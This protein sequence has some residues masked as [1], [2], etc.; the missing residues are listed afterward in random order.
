MTLNNHIMKL[1]NLIAAALSLMG[2]ALYAQVTIGENTYATDTLMRRQVGPGMITTIVRIPDYPLNVYI[3][4]TDLNNPYNRVETTLGYN[5]LGRTETLVNAANRNRTATKRPIVG[6]NGNFWCVSAEYPPREFELGTPYCSVVRNDSIYVNAETNAD[7]WSYGPTHTGGTAIAQDKTLY[8]GIIIP[9]ATITS[10]KLPNPVTFSTVNRRC[11]MD[12]ITLWTPA[13]SRTREFEDNWVTYTEK[14]DAHA[15]NYYLRLKE[16]SRWAINQDMTFVV[17][18]IVTDA[19]RQTLGD[20]DACFTAT[21]TQK[22]LLAPL[23]VGDEITVNYAM[24]YGSDED[25]RQQPKI[26]NMIEGLAVV[27]KNGELTYRNYDDSYNTRTY[28]RTAYGASADGKKL[29]MMVIDMSTSKKYGYSKGCSTEVMC[30][31]MKSLCPDVNNIVAMDAGGSAMM[32][33][34]GEIINTTT[35]GTPRAIA[36]GWLVEAVGEEDNEVASIAFDDY[37]TQIPI[38]STYR[39]KMLGYNQ[40]GELVDTDVQGFSLSCDEALG[41]A[42]GNTFT[43]GGTP[44]QGTLTATL[45]GMTATIPVT[46]LPAQP[47]IK[48]KPVIVI[49][50]REYPVEV[51]ATVDNTTYTYDHTKL[52]WDIDHP[53]IASIEG[54]VLKGIK[55]GIANITC[56]IGDFTDQDEVHVEISDKPYIH[57]SLDGWEYGG[58]GAKN[59]V[60]DPETGIATFTMGTS[61]TPYLNMEKDVT[62]FGLPDSIG[63][64]FSCTLQVPSVQ[65]DVRNA[66][67]TSMNYQTLDVA[68]SEDTDAPHTVCIDLGQLGGADHVTTYP[69]S[70]KDIQF[71]LKKGTNKDNT[72]TI[73]RI[74]A[75]YPVQQAQPVL[76]DVNGDGE[77]G[78]ADVTLLVSLLMSQESNERSDVN[79]DGETG[80]ADVTALVQILLQ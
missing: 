33:V 14:G 75:H 27:M 56:Q 80:V 43:A 25:V 60:M 18:N 58:S 23:N 76:G 19:D 5:T 16:G 41:V 38:Y 8:L 12:A 45:N 65:I 6:C 7:N 24:T 67:F 20:Y 22:D 53:E 34:G 68:D 1:K 61:R 63:V 52:G 40:R 48:H 78:V 59:I 55:N 47:A 62:F 32:L 66:A 54:G 21:G 71:N 11:L 26:E 77:V 37:R 39:P 64:T 29:T 50:Q 15:D 31:V 28:S 44:Q 72:L 69:I 3:T 36:C 51:T 74:F 79:G 2:T 17:E 9:S 46:L 35:E 49:D 10:D 4:E 42:E 30:Q 13:Y 57:Q 73:H 70:I